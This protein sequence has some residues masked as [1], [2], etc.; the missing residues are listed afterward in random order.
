MP[1]P[2]PR[3]VKK[4]HRE[5]LLSMKSFWNC[6]LHHVVKFDA[7]CAAVR[8]MD[9]AIKTVCVC[10]RVCTHVCHT[11]ACRVVCVRV[12]CVSYVCM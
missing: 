4:V 12:M 2:C 11:Y 8:R 10:V 3:L 6:M 7:L 9:K 5:A 1:L